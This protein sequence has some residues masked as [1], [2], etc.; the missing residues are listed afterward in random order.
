[1]AYNPDKFKIIQKIVVIMLIIILGFGMLGGAVYYLF[2][3][4]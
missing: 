3:N 1:M 4:I 2:S